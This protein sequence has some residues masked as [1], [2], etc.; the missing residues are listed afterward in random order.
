MGCV[1]ICF[2]CVAYAGVFVRARMQV[3]GCCLSVKYVCGSF[4]AR[5]VL[6][7]AGEVVA[8]VCTIEKPKAAAFSLYV[9]SCRAES[10]VPLLH[11]QLAAP[12]SGVLAR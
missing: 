8:C 12:P 9:L 2:P 1:A 6:R 5:C 7:I 3:C 11:Q 4:R 10:Q